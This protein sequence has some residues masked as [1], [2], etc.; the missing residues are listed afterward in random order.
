M[1]AIIFLIIPIIALE[2]S[3]V[4]AKKGKRSI[5]LLT[6]I[7]GCYII[8][9]LIALLNALDKGY[10]NVIYTAFKTIVV[11]IIAYVTSIYFA[12]K[13]AKKNNDENNKQ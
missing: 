6:I 11:T 2:I 3:L 12:E 5:I 10:E 7:D 9:S 4:R 13:E 8:F 1:E